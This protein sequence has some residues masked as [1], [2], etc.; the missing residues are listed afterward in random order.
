LWE[1][2]F[3]NHGEGK[4][5]QQ[6]KKNQTVKMMGVFNTSQQEMVLTAHFQETPRNQ[7]VSCK[8]LPSLP[9][10][11]EKNSNL[12]FSDWYSAN[13]FTLNVARI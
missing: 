3:A 2:L 12:L 8:T 1:E 10:V 7:S 9:Y 4:S 6:K 5:K 13:S 11:K